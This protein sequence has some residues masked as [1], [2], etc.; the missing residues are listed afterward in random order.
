VISNAG[1]R[2]SA[3]LGPIEMFE[4]GPTAYGWTHY[5]RF[6]IHVVQA[7]FITACMLTLSLA[8]IA[9]LVRARDWR[10]L[11]VFLIVPTYYLCVQSAL[12]TERRYVIAIHYF[13]FALAALPIAFLFEKFSLAIRWQ[14]TNVVTAPGRSGD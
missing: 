3:D 12:H 8:G 10:T 6:L 5:P 11:A 14:K 1:A 4:L 13:L 9:L 7:P 2:P